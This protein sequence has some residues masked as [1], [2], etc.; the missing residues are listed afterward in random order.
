MTAMDS[1]VSDQAETD[2][3]MLSFD[4]PDDC[5]E[6]AAG[7]GE[8]QAITLGVCTYWYYCRWPM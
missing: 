3:D 1:D 2:D 6:R 7:V 5:L 4:I 8:G